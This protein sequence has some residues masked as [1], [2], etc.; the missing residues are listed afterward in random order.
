MHST[1]TAKP[2]L[3]LLLL[4]KGA[5]C[6]GPGAPL[7]DDGLEWHTSSVAALVAL[8]QALP[9]LQVDFEHTAAEFEGI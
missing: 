4:G 3:S 5:V 1:L 7:L 8:G 2:R 6:D 9:H